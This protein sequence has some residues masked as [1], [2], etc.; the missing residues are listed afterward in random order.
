VEALPEAA[1]RLL[2]LQA[3]EIM[4][5]LVERRQE[6]ILVA[7]VVEHLPLEQMLQP[8]VATA[9]LVQHLLFLA[10]L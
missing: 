7:V 5:E 6:T 9:A 4:A 8:M 1:T 3:K 2:S 10:L